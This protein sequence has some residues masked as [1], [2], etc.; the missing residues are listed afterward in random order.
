MKQASG[1]MNLF[2]LGMLCGRTSPAHSLPT[3]AK[4]SVSSSKNFVGSK[5]K[6]PLFL[7]L[8]GGGGL[9]QEPSWEKGIPSLGGCLMLNFGECP[10]V[11]EESGLWQILEANVPQKYFLSARA[12]VG[13]LRRAERRGKELPEILETALKQQIERWQKY[14]SPLPQNI[15]M[16]KLVYPSCARTLTARQDGSP[17]IDRGQEIVVERCDAF[18]PLAGDKA[19]SVGYTE[20]KSHTLRAESP[21]ACVVGIDIYNATT[22][23]KVSKTLNSAATDSDHIPCVCYDARGNG[24][25]DTVPT[26]TGDHNSRITDYTAVC[27]MGI[28]SYNGQ[29]TEEV[30][31]TLGVNCGMASGRQGVIFAIDR[32]AFNQGQNAKYDIGIDESGIAQTVVARGPSAVCYAV[33][34]GQTAQLSL[35]ETARTLNCMHDPKAVLYPVYCLQGNGIDRADT[36]GCNGKG[37]TENV[38]YTL[39][40][41]DRHAVCCEAEGHTHDFLV[42]MREGKDGGGKGALVQEDKSGTIACNNDQVLFQKAETQYIVRR[43]TPLECCRLQGMPDWWLDGVEGSDAARYK[44]FGNGMALPNA[45]YIM[46]GFIDNDR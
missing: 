45:L 12:C 2:D 44:M 10:N 1:Q 41:V 43:L 22:T 33:G 14:G 31:S 20:N 46:E 32:A 23:G 35:S 39:N 18:L 34:N 38:S 24:D 26:I 3:R 8:Q 4:T 11:V 15:A 37:V 28:D 29:I 42:R 5:T 6:E 27:C 40:T 19:G 13:V 16:Q 25:G 21:T 17:C 36:A 30:S 9:I 7:N